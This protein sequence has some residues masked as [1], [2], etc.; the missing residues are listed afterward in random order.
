VIDYGLTLLLIAVVAMLAGAV[1]SVTGFGVGSLLTPLVGLQTGIKLA[2]AAVAIPHLAATVL[3]L[4]MVRKHVDMRVL[5]SFGLMS[6]VGGLA[7][8]FLHTFVESPALTAVFADL[9]IFAG[10]TGLAGLADRVR[11]KGWTAWVA[12]AVSGLLGG[13][14][15]NQGGIRSAALLG[16]D[17]PKRA[18]VATATAVALM[19]DGARTPIYLATQGRE[20]FNAWPFVAVATAG[21]LVGTAL[22]ERILRRV[23]ETAFRRIVSAIILVLG[24]LMFWQA[25]R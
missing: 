17:L 16:F 2:V 9:L 14:V 21:V 8:A 13:L 19:V 23:P 6:A 7:G 22:G 10:V 25:I 12:G 18:F 24:L 5:W 20:I 1:A 4:W 15:G 3:R 11:L